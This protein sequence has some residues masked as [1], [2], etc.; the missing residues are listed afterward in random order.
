ML[1]MRAQSRPFGDLTSREIRERAR[2]R[3]LAVIPTGCTERQGPHLPVDCETW[4]AETLL[5]AAA[6]KAED[7][8][9]QA[10]VLPTMPFGP[11]PE[12][13]HVGSGCID[14]PRPSLN[15]RARRPPFGAKPTG[16]RHVAGSL[17]A[18]RLPP[19]V[20]KG[21]GCGQIDGS[22]A[23]KQKSE[24]NGKKDGPCARTRRAACMGQKLG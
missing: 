20:K 5:L 6:E 15:H 24:Q 13:R 11:P 16:L 18:E 1:Q 23:S 8:A 14:L 9:V 12:P 7:H 10:L 2:L 22:D 3:W 17:Q 4:F 19:A 21:D